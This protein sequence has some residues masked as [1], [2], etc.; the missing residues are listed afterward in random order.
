MLRTIG[1][2]LEKIAH[3][4]VV[5]DDNDESFAIIDCDITNYDIVYSLLEPYIKNI[6][7]KVVNPNHKFSN[8]IITKKK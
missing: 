4:T 6:N 8:V 3:S 2:L 1:D 5:Y 7:V